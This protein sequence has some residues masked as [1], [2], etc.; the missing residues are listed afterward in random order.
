MEEVGVKLYMF[1]GLVA[2]PRLG[3]VQG[4]TLY[5]VVKGGALLIFSV[6]IYCGYF[7]TAI[8]VRSNVPG[9]DKTLNH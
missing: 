6:F 1:D 2:S 4:V 9:P 8:L 5:R 3:A 7:T